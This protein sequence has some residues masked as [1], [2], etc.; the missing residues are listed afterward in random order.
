MIE[1]LKVAA[2]RGHFVVIHPDAMHELTSWRILADRLCIENMDKRKAIGRTAKQLQTIFE[3][4]P[5]ATFCF[6]IGHARQVDPT[7]QEA[8]TFLQTFHDRL[9]QIHMSYVNSGSQHE[10]LNFE[11]VRAFQR[12]AHRMDEKIPIILETPVGS[13]DV[14]EEISSAESVF[15]FVSGVLHNHRLANG[16][17]S[18]TGTE[19][20]P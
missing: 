1:Q 15:S 18:T 4:L 2:D 8:E 10:R 17:K 11:C 9:R 16:A 13:G 7:M 14:D 5:E 19:P 12:V 6:D 20:K 3:K